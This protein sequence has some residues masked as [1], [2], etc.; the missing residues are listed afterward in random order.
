M[1]SHLFREAAHGS[2]LGEYKEA[3]AH[4]TTQ[5]II[6]DTTDGNEYHKAHVPGGYTEL[7]LSRET[8]LPID[9]D[10]FKG[11]TP[12]RH[13]RF[14][15]EIGDFVPQGINDAL[16]PESTTP[17]VN[18]VP[19]KSVSRKKGNK[20]DRAIAEVLEEV[21]ANVKEIQDMPQEQRP[22]VKVS[23]SGSFGKF[24]GTYICVIKEGNLVVLVQDSEVDGFTPPVN[25]E[26]LVK[27]DVMSDASSAD[28]AAYYLGMSFTDRVHKAK[29]MIF[30]LPE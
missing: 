9:G 5:A 21:S 13:Y 27:L 24:T 20:R 19:E 29:Y 2:T 12:G 4:P 1:S 25:D 30:H 11:F 22:S 18:Q 28:Y 6:V 8:G 26:A 3:T 17:V 15:K 23:L 16:K 10:R 7:P 14:D